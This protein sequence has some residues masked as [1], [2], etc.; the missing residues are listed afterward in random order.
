MA[1]ARSVVQPALGAQR[2]TAN[3]RGDY[4]DTLLGRFN[5]FAQSVILRISEVRD[6]GEMSRYDFYE[7][8][9]A[10]TATPPDV[11]RVDEKNIAEHAVF[12]V[13][14]V[15]FTTNHETDGMYLP[16][17]DRRHYVAWSTKTPAD[18]PDGYWKK[19]YDWYDAGGRS[20]VAAY[21][22]SYDLSAFDPKAPPPKTPAFWAIVD[23]NRPAE[24]AELAD[25]LDTLKVKDPSKDPE[26]WP[27]PPAVT[28]TM[29]ADASNAGLKNWLQDR[30]NARQIPH[31]MKTAGYV[32]YR[33]P[34]AKDGLWK[35]RRRR[36]VV[37]V[38]EELSVPERQ[39]AVEGLSQ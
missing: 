20:H 12:N 15:V 7:H 10:Y 1:I 26:D 36:Q 27:Y 11:L 33:N 22:A 39:R 3:V 14:G 25:V 18:F 2:E 32:A 34:A 6:L 28:L 23:A 29:V 9:K 24:D 17:D 37:Y 5:G 8:T 38:K 13:C 21:L 31:R 35:I 30:K 4:S 19:L 16:P